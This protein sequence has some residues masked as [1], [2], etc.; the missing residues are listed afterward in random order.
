[1][2]WKLSITISCGR[3]TRLKR[4]YATSSQRF[5]SE[6]ERLNLTAKRSSSKG[7]Q[8]KLN[9]KIV[10]IIQEEAIPL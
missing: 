4:R 9:P 7:L 2:N 8:G 10:A 3:L 6:G 1:M 5:V